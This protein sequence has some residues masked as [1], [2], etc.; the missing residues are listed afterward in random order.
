[1]RNLWIHNIK[2]FRE[3]QKKMTNISTTLPFYLFPTAVKFCRRMEKISPDPKT[4]LC[5]AVDGALQK[6]NVA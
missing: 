5:W 3:Q 1:M 4:M 6:H 2:E